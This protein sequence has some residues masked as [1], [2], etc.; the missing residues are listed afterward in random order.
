MNKKK[1]ILLIGGGVIALALV[2]LFVVVLSLDKIVKAGVE[3]VG[4]TLTKTT[5]TLDGVSIGPI[6]GFGEIRNLV[7]GNPEGY[8]GE[9]AITLGKAH[10]DLDPGSLLGDK[11]VVESMVVEGVDIILEGGLKENNLTAIQKNVASF[12]GATETTPAEPAPEPAANEGAAKK[13][14]VNHF[15]IE[16]AKVHLRLSMLGGGNLTITAPPIEMSDLGTGPDGITV[17]ELV[18]R[19]MKELTDDVLI[20]AGKAVADKGTEALGS[21]AKESGEAVNKAAEGVKNLFKKKE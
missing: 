20:A 16:G 14:Q 10:L 5:V 13:L 3:T 15:K 4:P 8:Q 1:L 7:V 17:A 2:A 18:K 12:A 19:A 21:A 6:R 9:Y 11:L